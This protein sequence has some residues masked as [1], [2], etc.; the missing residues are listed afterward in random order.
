MRYR[1]GNCVLS[2]DGR[3]LMRGPDI[4]A[5]APQV[6]DL[7][8]Y[9]IRHRERVV[10]KDELIDAIWDGRAISDAALTTRVYVARTAIGDNGREQQYIK[11]IARRGI[12]FIGEVEETSASPSDRSAI[13]LANFREP[14]PLG[15]QEPSIRV[16]AF[17]H[18]YPEFLR[19]VLPPSSR[20]VAKLWRSVCTVTCFLI[21]A[22]SAASWNNRLSWRVVIGL[23]TTFLLGN[24][25]RSC[26]GIP[27]S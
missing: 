3:E 18:A 23:P 1:F 22:A 10:T 20:W 26:R 2:L 14:V 21:P 13:K 17:R 27:T 5:L 8:A 7:L 11:T 19:S 12:R 16:D 9:L 15:P 4:I 6:F 24:S 25:Q